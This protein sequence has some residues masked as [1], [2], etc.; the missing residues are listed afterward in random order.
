[1]AKKS[2]TVPQNINEEY[3]Q[4]SMEILESFPKYRHP[5]D[6]FAF[7]ED[8]AVLAPLSRKQERL[9]NEKIEEIHRLCEEGSLFVSRSDHPTYS[10][11]I[12][13]QLDL[14]LQDKNLKE[15]EIADICV[16][17]LVM[18]YAN[19][20][21]QPVKPFLEQLFTDVLVVT[22][23]LSGDKNRLKGFCR[24]LFRK[25][26]PARHAVNC[27]S[28]GLWLWLSTTG[29][30]RRK[31]FDNMALGLL[32]HDIGMS[33]VPPFILAKT[34]PLKK[35][36]R[37]KILPH[38]LQGSQL[39]Q[40]LEMPADEIVKACFEHHERIDGSG[41]PQHTKGQV[42]KP[43]RLTAVVD[44]FSAM[45]TD[46]PYAKRKELKEAAAELMADANYD[47][48]FTKLLNSAILGK[49]FGELVDMDASLESGNA[50]LKDREEHREHEDRHAEQQK[51]EQQAEN[52]TATDEPKE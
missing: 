25:H 19:F 6:L 26:E 13:K 50:D 40:R 18:R 10:R 46:R 7:R 3:Y 48:E 14:I 30:V 4:I 21:D 11:Y 38:P 32:V 36:E 17:A 37:E 1:M 5:V 20:Y 15:A 52:S 44:S 23:Y 2:A 47:P 33:K 16:R 8:I 39:L 29:E 45:I 49:E 41:Y 35:E 12:V 31:D 43:G 22:E 27:F 28:L 34:T 42:S 9:S 51:A 24:R